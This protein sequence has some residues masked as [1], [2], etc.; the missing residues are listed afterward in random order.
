[1]LRKNLP[2]ILFFCLTQQAFSQDYLSSSR[3]TLDPAYAPFYH[4]VASGDPL[5]DRVIIWTRVTSPV[6]ATVS[7]GWQVSLDT[8]F[9]TIFK[10]GSALT[11]SSKDYT[12]KVDVTGIQAGSWYFYRFNALGKNSTIGRTRTADLG[13]NDSLRFAVVSCSNY[14]AG[15]FHA[16]KHIANRNDLAAVLHLGDYIYEY[17]SKG[18]GS[19]SDTTRYHEP[20]AEIVDL[21][22]YRMRHSQYKL[23]PDLRQCHQQYPFI[24]VWDDHETANDSYHDGAENHTPATEGLWTDRKSA[25]EKA[26]FE[27]MPIRE[28]AGSDTIHRELKYGNLVNLIMVD[29]RLEGR[30]KQAA[31]TSDPTLNDPNRTLLGSIQLDWFKTKLSDSV[32]M[33]KLVGNQVM[34]SPLIFN[35][36]P[37][38]LDQWDGYPAERSKVFGHIRSNNIKNVVFLTGDIHTSWGNDLPDTLSKYVSATGAGSIAVEYVCTSITSPGI[39]GIG[40]T[41]VPVLKG[42]NP[43]MKYIDLEK[44]GYLVLDINK[45]RTQGDW[46]YMSTVQSKTY[47][48]S[49]G[50]SWFTEKNKPFLKQATSPVNAKTNPAPF[51]PV[52]SNS[53]GIKTVAENGVVISC[54]PNP[55]ADLM[56]LQYYLFAP[57]KMQIE[58]MD[59]NGKLVFTQTE[60]RTSEGLF[61][62]AISLT[63]LANGVYVLSLKGQNGLM[64]SKQLVKK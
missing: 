13:D 39:S 58:V 35:G 53:V 43:Y 47:T 2:A 33:W 61:E 10:S 11:D 42:T 56:S 22:E 49:T 12:V 1:M 45:Q 25:A 29:T 41:F 21:G 50:G 59:L 51:A 4:G 15:Y 62:S 54:Y 6:S 38:N 30:E 18:Y 37:F 32:A 48:T 36:T 64:Y 7:V 23:D 16:Y 44:K 26:Y 27:W 46:V 8:T 20:A 31:N 5:S 57:Q 17:E 55:T 24:T 63:N 9:A 60:N 34:V 52:I 14:Q 28:T 3:A 19:F 40:N